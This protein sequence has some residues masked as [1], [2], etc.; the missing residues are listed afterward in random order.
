MNT[1]FL[2]DN[3]K[4]F[5]DN[6]KNHI[7]KENR[8]I[9]WL[10]EL[11]CFFRHG[12]SP[13]D[14]FRYEFYK[15]SDYERSRFI[16]YR[17]SQRLIKQYNN[18]EFTKFFQ[19]KQLFNTKFNEFLGREWIDCSKASGDDFASFVHRHG[20]ILMKP[21]RGGQGKG[22]FK[23]SDKDIR[24]F[25]LERHKDF[26]AEQI[27]VQHPKMALLNSSSVN[28]IRV[29][30]FKG[31]VIACALR[32]GGEGAIVDNLHSNGVCA[33]LDV[34]KGIIDNLCINNKLEKF[35]YHPGSHIQLVGFQVP[36]W[37]KVIQT[38]KAAARVVPEVQYIGWDIA[39]TENGT[40]LI[41]GNHDPGHDVVQMI[42][43]TGL[44]RDIQKLERL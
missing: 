3:I 30:T 13:D 28:T 29:L 18:P 9:A 39:V 25:E 42:A 37:D 19:E 43:Q 16:T 8:S 5:S 41:E 1:Q 38:A 36:N 15:K 2:V 17:R 20:C 11:Y 27:I 21:L 44:Y 12:C 32:I 10:S 33:H 31:K 23:L 40:A 22:I 6:T 35:L 26:L 34:K 14:Y 4:R 24:T 7:E